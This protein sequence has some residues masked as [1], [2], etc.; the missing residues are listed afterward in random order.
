MTEAAQ[1]TKRNMQEQRQLET[2]AIA[3]VRRALATAKAD[4]RTACGTGQAKRGR[5]EPPSTIAAAADEGNAGA[6]EQTSTESAFVEGP[7]TQEKF[8]AADIPTSKAFASEVSGTENGCADVADA[9]ASKVD[10]ATHI[11]VCK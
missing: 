2:D 10:A 4:A 9:D 7:A 8:N 5:T 1:E 3:E 11:G 6:G